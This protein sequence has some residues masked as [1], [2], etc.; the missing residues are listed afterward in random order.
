[1]ARSTR[2]RARLARRVGTP[3]LAL[4]LAFLAGVAAAQGPDPA[5]V[6]DFEPFGA[7]ERSYQAYEAET[8]G[9]IVLSHATPEEQHA[10]FDVVGPDGY[11]EHFDFEDDPGGER[12]LDEL[13]PGVYSIAAS[14]EGLEL[15]HVVVEVRP[16][17]IVTIDADLVRWEQGAFAP[18]VYD[19]YAGYSVDG[20]DGDPVGDGD[21][22]EFFDY[23]GYPFGTFGLDRGTPYTGESGFAAL[24]VD[25]RGDDVDTVVTGPNGYSEELEGDDVATR[26]WPGVYAVASTGDGYD[27]AVTTI[28]VEE[29]VQYEVTPTL[30]AVEDA[31]D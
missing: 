22:D 21:G 17:E 6:E 31:A 26:L 4:L 12:I 1:M 2:T 11:Y 15:V 3:L 20:G 24:A 5:S 14:D 28:E 9:A 7:V 19:P 13:R 8:R 29:D 25:V 16:G 27:L 23:P 10:N 30:V 18:G